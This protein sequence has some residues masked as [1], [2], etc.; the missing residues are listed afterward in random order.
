MINF[1]SKKLDL[2][3]GIFKR[4][5]WKRNFLI[6]LYRA[7]EFIAFNFYL[8]GFYFDLYIKRFV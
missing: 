6:D 4:E 1:E 5:G 2:F 7:D 3:V 8:F